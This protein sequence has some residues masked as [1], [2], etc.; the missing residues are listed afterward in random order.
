[1]KIHDLN[2]YLI[3]QVLRRIYFQLDKS[4]SY[5]MIDI[6]KPGA[7]KPICDRDVNHVGKLIYDMLL[8]DKPCM[9]CRFGNTEMSV[10]ANQY[11]IN[12]GNQDGIKGIIEYIQGKRV[13]WWLDKGW[14]HNIQELSGFY[15]T[16]EVNIRKFYTLMID[17]MKEVDILASWIK[18]EQYFEEYLSSAYKIALMFE[19]LYLAEFPWTKAL[20]GKKILII[21][22]FA[23]TIQEQY[24]KREYIWKN[25]ETLPNF[26][27]QTIQAIQS[28]GGNNPNFPSWFDALEYM[29]SEIEKTDFEICLLGCGAYGF[30][31]AAHVKRLGKKAVHIGGALQLLFGI[32]GKRWDKDF[33]NIYNE[34]WVRPN[35]SEKPQNADSVEGG[36]YW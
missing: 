13:G 24:K 17:S 27:L 20:E 11:E 2:R 16:T 1:M 25:R 31:L 15:P 32:K 35:E 33:A 12:T 3:L 6:N 8:N 30:P 14:L 34:Y 21:H 22:P 29:K 10:L 26:D 18:S 19:Q 9:I 23:S 36:C 5:K 4:A 28:L 7:Y